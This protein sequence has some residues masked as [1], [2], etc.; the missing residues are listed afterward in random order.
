MKS[1]FAVAILAATSAAAS[2][3]FGRQSTAPPDCYLPCITG[4]QLPAECGMDNACL[5]RNQQFVDSTSAC[6]ASSCSG[7]DLAAAQKFA[8]DLCL[9]ASVTLSADTASQT[10]SQTGSQSGS[11]TETSAPTQ[12][13]TGSNGALSNGANMMASLA[14]IGLVAL[15]L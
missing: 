3:L 9:Q 14:G 12:T 4:A 8:Q 1:S 2:T 10:A 15:A 6:I 7:D 5:C 13:S 11:Q